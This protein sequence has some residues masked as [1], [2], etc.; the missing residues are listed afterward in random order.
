MKEKN[1]NLFYILMFFAMIGWGASWINAKVL[2]AYINEFEMIFIRYIITVFTMIPIILYMKKS[3]KIDL[4][5]F[6]LILLTSIVFIAYLK[7][8]FLGTKLGT[9]SLGGAFVT[10]LVPILTFLMLVSLK[11]KK[12]VKKDIF[13]LSLGAVGVLTI[14]NI[15]NTNLDELFVKS[16]VYFVFAAFLWSFVTIL[17][18]KSIK[19]SPI[20]FTFYLYIVTVVIDALFFVNFNAI[21]YEK[22]DSIFWLNIFI[23][24]IVASTFSNTIYFLGIEKLGTSEVSSFIF[25]VPFSAIGLSYLFLDEKINFSM[26]LGTILTI[27]AV[28]ILNDIKLKSISK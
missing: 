17:S 21:A 13:A 11:E 25:L 10:T 24:T 7:Y 2:S 20:I 27:I 3:F 12:A 8:Y 5:S 1:K 26:L 16:N 23:I 18:A 6:L 28:V 15:W 4:K 19:I 9:A 22:F 14:L